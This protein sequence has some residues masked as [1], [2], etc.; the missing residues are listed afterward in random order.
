MSGHCRGLASS[1]TKEETT[2][3]L[4]AIDVGALITLR[5]LAPTD[6]RKMVVRHLDWLVRYHEAAPDERR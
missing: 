5:A 1:E 4:R 2:N 3:S 6:R